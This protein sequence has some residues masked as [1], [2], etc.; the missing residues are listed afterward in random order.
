LL[1]L[2]RNPIIDEGLVL[3]RHLLET[4]AW[5]RLRFARRGRNGSDYPVEAIDI[6]GALLGAGV[7]PEEERRQYLL[8][9][10]KLFGFQVQAT[11]EAPPA[12]IEE[13]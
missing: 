3:N 9:Y 11:T 7:Y 12:T 10:D 6:L 2:T 1:D 5:V 8:K 13:Q 4:F